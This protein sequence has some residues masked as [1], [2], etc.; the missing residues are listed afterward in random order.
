MRRNPETGEVIDRSGSAATAARLAA[1]LESGEFRF[2]PD[3]EDKA[4]ISWVL[5]EWLDAVVDHGSRARAALQLLALLN[6]R[7][8]ATS[9]RRGLVAMMA[10]F[11]RW[12]RS[13]RGSASLLHPARRATTWDRLKLALIRARLRV[14]IPERGTHCAKNGW[15]GSR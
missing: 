10:P 3:E 6:R 1:A 9:I 15:R 11:F 4:S 12:P 5:R 7:D 14:I 8:P 13:E 2:A